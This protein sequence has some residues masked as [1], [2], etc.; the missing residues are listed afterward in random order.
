M[1]IFNLR[2]AEQ[3]SFL[4]VHAVHYTH[5]YT[6]E[7]GG[8]EKLTDRLLFLDFRLVVIA[9]FKIRFVFVLLLLILDDTT[10]GAKDN[11]VRPR[12]SSMSAMPGQSLSGPRK[13][14]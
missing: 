1:S 4:C 9:S 7:F 6:Y 13:V 3:V 12:N 11:W 10:V 2:I 14:P 5:V 8:N